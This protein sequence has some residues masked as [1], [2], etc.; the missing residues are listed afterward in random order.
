MILLSKKEIPPNFE[1]S[2]G[3]VSLQNMSVNAFTLPF[4]M[5]S[6]TLHDVVAIIGLPVDGDKNLSSMMFLVVSWASKLIRRIT[7]IQHLSTP[8]IGEMA[9]WVILNP[10]HLIYFGSVV[11]SFVL[12]RQ[13]WWGSLRPMYL[14]FSIE[15]TSI[16]EPFSF[17]YT[18]VSSRSC[19]GCRKESPSN[20][21]ES[22][23]FLKLGIQHYFLI[24][25]FAETP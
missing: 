5:M 24:V 11:S 16:S 7:P 25:F 14:L 9:L 13:L 1:F 23:W 22:F 8:L 18:R 3:S 4:V 17:R 20:Q 19:L 21:C 15:A 12:A 2:Y 10:R 6:P